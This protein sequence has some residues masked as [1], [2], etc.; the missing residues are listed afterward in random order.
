MKKL[1]PIIMISIAM[2]I[3]GCNNKD[4][5]DNINKSDTRKVT[6]EQA[7]EIALKHA[8]LINDQVSF[9]RAETDLDNGIE[10]YD[11]EFYHE[12]I[13]YDYEINVANGEIIEYDHDVENYNINNKQTPIR[14]IG[15][16]TEEQGKIISVDQAKEIALKHAN[17]TSDQVTFGKSE[18]DFDD[19]IQKYYIEFY[20]NNREHSFEIDA[21]TG[22]VLAN[23]KD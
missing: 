7:K 8:N 9:I 16:A 15:G 5:N 12:N 18:L 19:G 6:L 21:N 11:I 17:L 23:E 14:N 1:L 20:Y 13:E 2:S 4:I 10:K 22:K 3:S